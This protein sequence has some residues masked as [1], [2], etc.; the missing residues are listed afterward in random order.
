MDKTLFIYESEI[1]SMLKSLANK[2]RLQILGKLSTGRS[3]FGSLQNETNLSKTALAHHIEVLLDSNMINQISRGNYELSND[4]NELLNSIK[5]SFMNTQKMKEEEI[6]R[7]ADYILRTHEKRGP[8]MS[9][10]NIRI[11]ELEPMHVASVRVISTSPEYDAWQRMKAWAQPRKLLENLKEH[12]VFG[13]NNPNPSIGKKEYGYE[14]WIKID[15]TEDYGSNEDI[16][17]KK[18]KGGRY[19]VATSKLKE[20]ID[21][22]GILKTW[23]NLV[24]WVE[25]SEYEMRTDIECLEK[26][27]N[28]DAG[29]DDL[30]LDLYLPLSEKISKN[31]NV[32]MF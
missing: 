30:V 24:K 4:G 31:M 22:D 20:D 15:P 28:P 26:A 3:T 23:K 8:Q 2:K 16:E 7:K 13:F 5:T 32:Q 27:Q 19:A 21:S 17:F 14:F 12:P 10:T 1:V 29:E 6:V 18:F 25:T 11:V 9:E